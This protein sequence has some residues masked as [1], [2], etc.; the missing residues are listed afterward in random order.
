MAAS[1]SRPMTELYGLPGVD[2]HLVQAFL[3]VM[4]ELDG[5]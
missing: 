1:M 2:L 3:Y 4:L 5:G